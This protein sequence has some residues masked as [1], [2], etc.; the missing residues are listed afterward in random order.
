MKGAGAGEGE[1]WGDILAMPHTYRF[2]NVRPC[3]KKTSPI[4]HV[5]LHSVLRYFEDDDTVGPGDLSMYFGTSLLVTLVTYKIYGRTWNWNTYDAEATGLV[6]FGCSLLVA[7]CWLHPE[8]F[9]A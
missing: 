2:H 1:R 5:P 6:V 9:P 7:R 8:I 4:H 3:G